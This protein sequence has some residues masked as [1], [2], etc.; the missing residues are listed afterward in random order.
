MLKIHI[1]KNIGE[2]VNFFKLYSDAENII[3]ED[4]TEIQKYLAEL[5]IYTAIVL[6]MTSMIEG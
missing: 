6:A 4:E 3:D 5:N 1:W 2:K